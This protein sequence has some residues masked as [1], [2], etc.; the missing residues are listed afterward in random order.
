MDT[1]ALTLLLLRTNA[2]ADSRQC[3]SVL[4]YLSSSEELSTLNVLDERRNI[5]IYRATLNAR[6]VSTVETTLGFSHSHLLGETLVYL[7]QTSGSAVFRIQFRHYDALDSSALLRLHR[8]TESLTP[9][10]F[11][12]GE[13]FDGVVSWVFI[14]YYVGLFLESSAIVSIAML[15]VMLEFLLFDVLESTHTLEH[16]IP[17]HESTVKLRAVDADKLGFSTDGKTTSTTHSSTV[18]HDS[19][20]RNVSRNA[21]FLSHET[22][23]FHHDRRSDSECFVDMLLL[24]EFLNTDSHDSLFTL[25]AVVSHDDDLIRRLANLIF[26]DDEFGSTTS[27]DREHAVSRSL[28]T[29]DD[30]EHRRSTKST[31][32]ADYSAEVFDVGRI[33]ERAHDVCNTVTGIQG[34][35]F[36]GRE[37]HFLYDES[38]SALL[39]VSIS[40]GERHTFAVLI[41]AH[42]DEVARLSALGNQR[43]LDFHAEHFL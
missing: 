42:D 21:V 37:S 23:E 8:L 15:L 19:V 5:D 10:R 6:R 20:E 39:N 11:A 28:Q 26:H 2:S 7:L 24:T 33:T 3:R 18:H 38:D 13:H 25:R 30:R 1:L 22:R 41:D 40:D 12:V 43:S 4:Q 35:E 9:R 27:D 32:C 34:A 36:L 31:T 14:H 29:A 16:L 17:I